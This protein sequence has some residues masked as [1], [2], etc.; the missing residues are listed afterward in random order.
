MTGDKNES[1]NEDSDLQMFE[2]IEVEEFFDMENA[3]IISIWAPNQ[4]D[5]FN[6]LT[7]YHL[8]HI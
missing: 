5:P 8:M 3:E 1:P 7:L 2:N 6:E 4:P